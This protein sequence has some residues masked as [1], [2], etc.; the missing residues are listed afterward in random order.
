M[1]AMP[2][3]TWPSCRSLL[4]HI[5][6]HLQDA[7]DDFMNATDAAMGGVSAQSNSLNLAISPGTAFH[8]KYQCIALSD[9]QKMLDSHLHD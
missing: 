6:T 5:A 4:L 3:G 2:L 7:F 9:P 1:R 8:F